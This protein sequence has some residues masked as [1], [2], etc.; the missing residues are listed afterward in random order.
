M[1]LTTE[2][3]YLPE[4]ELDHCPMIMSCYN[5]QQKKPFRFYNMWIDSECFIPL[6]ETN[7]NKPVHGC[8]MFRVLQRLKWIKAEFKLLNKTCFH[9]V[10]ATDIKTH[11]DLLMAQNALHATPGDSHLATVEKEANEAYQRA[12]QN[13]LSYLHQTAKLKEVNVTSISLVPK[14][15]VANFVSDFRPIACCSVIYKC[16]SK[17]MCS[18]LSQILPD[19]ISPTQG[20]F[21]A[22]RSILHNVM[23]CQDIIKLYN[24]GNSRPSCMMKLDLKKAYGT[25]EW[26]FIE[27]VMDEFG[28]PSHFIQLVMTC[29]TTTQYSLL[30]NGVPSPLI[31]PKRGLRQGDPLSPLLFTPCMEYFS[32]TMKLV[33]SH[34]NFRFHS[35]C[36]TLKLN[37]LC[38][39]DDL[40]L[41]C[42]GDVTSFQLMLEGLKLFSSTTGLQINPSKSSIY[43]SGLDTHTK[44]CL[45]TLYGYTID[46]LPFK[47]L[48]VSIISKKI[49]AGDCNLLVEKMVSIIKIWSSRHLSFAGRMQLVNFV[50]MSISVYWSQLFL[51]PAIIIKQNQC[52]MQIFSLAAVGKLAWAIEQK[53]DNLWVKW[54]HALYVKNKN[55]QLFVPSLAASWPVKFICKVKSVC[56]DKFQGSAWLTSSTYSIKSTYTRLC[57]QPD[58]THWS[59]F[60]WNRLTMPKHRF[61]LW[62]GLLDR[63]KTKARLFQYGIRVD[64]LCAICGGRPETNGHLFFE[65]SYS[66]DCLTEVLTWLGIKHTRK[67]VLQ[68]LNWTRRYCRN[69]FKR[70]VIFAAV[71]GLVYQIWRARNNS[72]WEGAVPAASVIIQALKSDVKHRIQ[73]VCEIN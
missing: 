36:K 52:N 66:Y 53:Q 17:I 41:F 70:K 47:Y 24:R 46:C 26:K 54:I 2:A 57:T 48:G 9:S 59:S 5:V 19:I 28:F 64:N 32:R 23:I 38:F 13:Y 37:H 56:N 10:E 40:L 45:A 73:Q 20:A 15:T 42:N 69:A 3:A 29:L 50:L 21:V 39:A 18:K 44:N 55:W 49:Q 8:H 12:H 62:L 68:V 14:L 63:H 31:Q 72:V 35:R 25:V 58:V 30:I 71:A 61:S 33:A 16:I 43:C 11:S 7:W 4:G 67:N 22:G 6:V 51:I 65:C 34:P 1:F 60:I 27:E